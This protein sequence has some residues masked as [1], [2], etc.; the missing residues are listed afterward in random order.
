[1]KLIG[2]GA[3]PGAAVGRA[4]I[5]DRQAVQEPRRHLAES[6]IE[7]EV[8]RLKDAVATSDLQ[9]EEIRIKLGA[10]PQDHGLILE[11]HRLMLKDPALVGTAERFIREDQIN[12]EWA[13]RRVIKQLASAFDAIDDPYFKERRND[14]EFVGSR[15]VQNLMGKVTDIVQTP[16]PGSIVVARELSPA[17]AMMLL[18]GKTVTGVILA[19]GGRT[20]HTAIVARAL[21]VPAVLGVETLGDA[22][23]KDDLIAMD[24]FTGV[25]LVNPTEADQR[26]FLEVHRRH[27][28]DEEA[29]VATR[30]LEALTTDGHSVTLRANIELI[31]E[32]P[33][34]LAHGA[35]GV[36]LYRTEFLYLNRRDLP[37][38][39]EHYETYKRLLQSLPGVQVTVRT[40]D[41]GGEK[42]MLGRHRPEA[43]PSLGLRAI[44]YCL[45]HPEM[46][47]PQ[48]R[49][50]WRASV[51]G[52]LRVMFP[53]I[54]GVGELRRAKR[55]VEEAR[56][57]VLADGYDIAD[58]LPIGIMVETPAA[59]MIADELAQESAFFAIGTNDLIQY[60]VAIDR[61]NPDVAYL[62]Q[63]LHPAVL[64]ML[65]QILAAGRAHNIPVSICGELAGDPAYTLILIALGFTELSMSGTSIP[66]VKRII[67]STGR[68]AAEELLDQALRLKSAP[69]IEMF[70]RAEMARRFPEICGRLPE[71]MPAPD[72]GPDF[73]YAPS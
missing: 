44:R 18:N 55:H 40:F 64:R 42:V 66:M 46:F 39:E 5:I 14:V 53:L 71:Q 60:T 43:N 23:G 20:S 48:L 54:S 10:Q 2:V 16:P 30:D 37:S 27:L 29:A 22:I 26:A 15:V 47:L 4:F 21:D 63:P 59:V 73:S 70:V 3:S 56:L 1:V 51:H 35:N 13:V 8:Q 61:R 28:A 57:Q 38:E 19:E 72:D 31:E 41:L 33:S 68:K 17:D 49:A 9:L 69:E 24:G 65:D 45:A 32:I 12:A 7:S 36:G 58:S 67:R 11:A 34:I 6:E 52:N 50:L 25:V 62:Y